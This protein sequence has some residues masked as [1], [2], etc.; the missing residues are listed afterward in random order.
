MRAMAALVPLTLVLL[1]GGAG[2]GLEGDLGRLQGRWTTKVGAKKE[3]TISLEIKDQTVSATV[4]ALGLKVLAEGEVKIDEKASPKKVDWVKL[5]T[6]DG[7]EFPELL[8]I[9]ELTG[10]KLKIRNGGLNDD[11]PKAFEAGD[12]YWG[13]VVVF[14]R[15][16]AK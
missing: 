13:E 2:P 1:S 3:V 11:R 5:C 12:G 16:S 10:D 15:S 9:Y 8:G 7:H 6:P 14:E 4:M